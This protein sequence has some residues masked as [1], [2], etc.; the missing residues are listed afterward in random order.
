M[1]HTYKTLTHTHTQSTTTDGKL[2]KITKLQKNYTSLHTRY[3][4]K[5]MYVPYKPTEQITIHMIHSD[6]L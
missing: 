5:N 2:A 6:T 3:T 1:I 4:Y